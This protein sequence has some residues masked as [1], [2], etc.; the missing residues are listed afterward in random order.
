MIAIEE[1]RRGLAAAAV[2]VSGA[3]GDGKHKDGGDAAG[4]Q[5]EN[6]DGG[7]RE[8]EEEDLM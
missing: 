5:T 4:G 1:D 8:E 7:R 2:E 6:V 3:E